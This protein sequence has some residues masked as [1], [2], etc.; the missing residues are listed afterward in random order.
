[1]A[2]TFGVEEKIEKK[3]PSYQPVSLAKVMVATDFSSVSSHALDYA[4]S[5]ARRFR[6]RLYLTH[7]ITYEGHGVMEPEVGAPSRE[8]LRNNAEAQAKAVVDSGR[9]YGVPNEVMIEEGPLWPALESLIEQ[10]K[11]D[12]L[13]L[14]THGMSGPMKVLFGSS[15]EE[16]FRQARLP[17]LT[18]G[19]AVTLDAPFE[20][21]FKTILFA[22]DFGPGTDREAA[23]A[24]SLA[25]EH[26]AKL[27]LLHVIPHTE[28]HFDRETTLEKD[29]F[30]HQLQEL[31]PE[32][33]EVLCKPE[34]HL[35]YG[36]PVEEILRVA[37]EM[38]A[39]L[40]VIGAKK[41]GSLAGHI[42]STKAFN[43]VRTAR[44][45]VLTIKS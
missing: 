3:V 16:I 27:V 11:I 4:V 39:D 31:V 19:P 15:A 2:Y 10:N 6:S 34:F 17:V 5:L 33:A 45:P 36:H 21:E 43:L 18:V 14:G 44:C 1:M 28:T 35:A 37:K 32:G 38:K 22:T 42:P 26:R 12:L 40:I 29:S 20:A 8:Q 25:Q 30:T 7:V 41:R 9:L 13:V 24:Y 23:F